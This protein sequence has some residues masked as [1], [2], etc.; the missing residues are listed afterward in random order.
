MGGRRDRVVPPELVAAVSNAGGLGVTGLTDLPPEEIR[1]CI[2]RIRELTDKPF[3]IDLLLPA[4]MADPDAVSRDDAW[5]RLEREYPRHVE[6]VRKLAE[7]FNLPGARPENQFIMSPQ[8]I[9]EQVEVVLHERV[10]LFAAALGDPGWVVPKARAVG[11]KVVGLAGSVRHALRQKEAEVDIVVAQGHEAG[12]HVGTIGTFVLIPEVVDAVA[13]LPVLGAG[14]IA[15]GRGIAAALTLGAQGVW[16]GT[17]FLLSEESGIFDAQ[18]EAIVNARTE[19][20]VVTRAFT[21]KTARDVRGIVIQ[22]WEQSGLRPLPMPLQWILFRDFLAA[23]ERAGRYDLMNNP[24]GQVGGRLH[25]VRPARE[26]FET[27]VRETIEVLESM[28]SRVRYAREEQA[29]VK[30]LR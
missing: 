1:R 2:R 22:R 27:M 3:G 18:K 9:R 12:G 30:V 23:A 29:D 10:P 28:P 11:T 17:A 13:P 7:E 8:T 21:G 4:S 24:A 25:A 26:I 15:E 6:F 16:V 20:F 5:R 14:G 19:D